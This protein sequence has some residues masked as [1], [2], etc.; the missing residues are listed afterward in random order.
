MISSF[1]SRRRV[2]VSTPLMTSCRAAI[3]DLLLLGVVFRLSGVV[4]RV[5]D[6]LLP[7]RHRRVS[8]GNSD[9]QLYIAFR[10]RTGRP[11]EF[12]VDGLVAARCSRYGWPSVSNR[13]KSS[14]ASWVSWAVRSL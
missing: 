12:D 13:L 7:G 10:G 8:R 5:P 14:T 3:C 11:V 2:R 4:E 9:F 1:S 6:L